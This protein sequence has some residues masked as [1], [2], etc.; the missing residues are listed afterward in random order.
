MFNAHN[1]TKIIAGQWYAFDCDGCDYADDPKVYIFDSDSNFLFKAENEA[2]AKQVV[3]EHN[4]HKELVKSL[5]HAR[6]MMGEGVPGCHEID[7]VLKAVKSH[8]V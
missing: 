4:M 1:K 7:E 6:F 3:H 8:T 5:Y 2:L